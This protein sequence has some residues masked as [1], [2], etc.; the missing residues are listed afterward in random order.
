MRRASLGLTFGAFAWLASACGGGW[1]PTGAGGSTRP[2]ESRGVTAPVLAMGGL[3][4]ASVSAGTFH[5]CVLDV[6]GGVRCSGLN[7]EQQ[8][9]TTA[10]LGSC[11]G[12][13]CAKRPLS[14]ASPVTFASIAAGQNHTCAVTAAGAAW[15]WGG[16]V[17]G[18][19]VGPLGGGDVQRSAAP[20]AVVG[21]LTFRV[22]AVG[23]W[24][25][26]GLTLDGAAYCWGRNGYGEVG[27]GTT[28]PRRAPV[29]VAGGHTFTTLAAGGTHVCGLKADGE[30]YCWGAN[31][32][33]QLGVGPAAT[34]SA[35]V[36]RP[37][38]VAGGHAYAQIVANVALTCGLAADGVAR[39]WGNNIYGELG[40]GVTAEYADVPTLVAGGHRFTALTAGGAHAC[41]LT[42][43]GA[44][45]CWGGNYFGKL[46][47]GDPDWGASQRAPV[48]VKGPPFVAISAGGSHV[49][50]LAV[51]RRVY[52]WG[53]DFYGQV[54][55]G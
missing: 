11:H 17:G 7:R 16:A 39:C 25:T 27:D 54:G 33:G 38:R 2:D 3:P 24:M 46:G 23:G 14:V 4:V 44:A 12:D 48:R 8:L 45:Y 50:A 35:I 42:A 1:D 49:C 10:Q 22:L 32:R 34:L 13:A 30:A 40:A 9:G 6:G 21:V 41:G 43:D 31:L 29:P 15:C 53:D 18:D 36:P 55:A 19:S 28:A 51:D 47:H 52:C 26:C 37:V 5:T 20:V